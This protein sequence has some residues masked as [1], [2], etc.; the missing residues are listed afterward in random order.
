MKNI[1][2]IIC[3]I[4]SGP[5]PV[6]IMTH[7]PSYHCDKNLRLLIYGGTLRLYVF[8]YESRS[9][10][11]DALLRLVIV[12]SESWCCYLHCSC[13][14][15]AL[16]LPCSNRSSPE[17]E[18]VHILSVDE[19]NKLGAKIIKAEMMGNMVRLVCCSFAE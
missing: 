10:G 1:W 17:D 8:I 15:Y 5:F 4:V 13:I 3:L 16:N 18:S 12:T 7:K 14:S 19:K 6:I 2:H 9:L 11:I